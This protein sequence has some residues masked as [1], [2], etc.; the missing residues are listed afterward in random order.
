MVQIPFFDVLRVYKSQTERNIKALMHIL[1]QVKPTMRILHFSY[2]KK[3]V[4][5]VLFLQDFD[6]YNVRRK[7]CGE[8]TEFWYCKTKN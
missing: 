4:G 3:N 1:L 7:K 5:V 2:T 8:F 6:L